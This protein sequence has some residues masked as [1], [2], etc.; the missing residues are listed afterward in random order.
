M[1]R[2]VSDGGAHEQVVA[3]PPCFL[4]LRLASRGGQPLR[5]LEI[6][7]GTGIDF[8]FAGLHPF[9]TLARFLH[10][11]TRCAGCGRVVGDALFCRSAALLTCRPG[12]RS[13]QRVADRMR[14]STR[15]MCSSVRLS[16]INP[17]G[18]GRFP[19]LPATGSSRL[20]SSRDHLQIEP[21]SRA[22][23]LGRIIGLHFSHR[24]RWWKLIMPQQKLE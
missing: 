22:D 4:E 9:G 13:A 21:I 17:H 14:C 7:N 12:P 1:V 8:G 18:G 5:R 11:V 19:P 15:P 10:F 23:G 16:L 2:M 24:A 3:P 6:K 20:L